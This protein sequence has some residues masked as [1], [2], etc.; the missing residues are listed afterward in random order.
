[1]LLHLNFCKRA[2]N[3]YRFNI[4]YCDKVTWVSR[5]WLL[6]LKALVLFLEK[7]LFF[8]WFEIEYCSYCYLKRTRTLFIKGCIHMSIE[9]RKRW[10]Y[11]CVLISGYWN[12]DWSHASCQCHEEKRWLRV[13]SRKVKLC[14]GSLESSRRKLV[15]QW[16]IEVAQR[17]STCSFG[18]SAETV[19]SS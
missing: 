4:Y 6:P 14:F 19:Y 9:F 8:P 11:T 16:V 7:L 3:I 5:I 1:M 2:T 12:R 10:Q 17:F 18:H 13:S 15:L